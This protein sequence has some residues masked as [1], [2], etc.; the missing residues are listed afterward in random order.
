MLEVAADHLRVHRTGNA[1]RHHGDGFDSVA[2]LDS[3]DGPV[4]ESHD[5]ATTLAHG[6]PPA[7]LAEMQRR[8]P[9]FAAL[10]WDGRMLRAVRDPFGLVPLFYRI[11]GPAIWLSSEVAPLL[12]LGRPAS[13]LEAL[14]AR[15]AGTPLD[16]RTGWTGIHRVLPGS[17]VEVRPG[18][19]QVRTSRYWLAPTRL[20]ATFRGSLEEAVSEFRERLAAAVK[21]CLAPRSAILLSGGLDSA[22]VA[23]T[24]RAVG[25]AI[26]RLV[27]VHFPSLPATHEQHYAASVAGAVGA[28]LHT[29]TGDLTPWDI[30]AELD[31]HGIPYS[32]LP[33]GMD[34]PPLAYLAAAGLTVALDGHDGDGILGPP[35][36]AWGELILG[37]EL[38]RLAVLCRRGGLARTLRGAAADFVPH[39]LRPTRRRTSLA[40]RTARYFT[41]PLRSRSI[42]AH[43][44]WAWPS[45]RWRSMQLLP[46]LPRATVSFEQK[47]IEAARYGIDLRH[48]FADR[49]LAE[50]LISLPC[51]IK[52]DPGRAKPLLVDALGDALPSALRQRSKSDYLAAVRARVDAGRHLGGIRAS[53]I[54]LPHVDYRRLL[55]DGDADPERIPIHLLVGL[56][57]AHRFAERTA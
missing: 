43:D 46:L 44:P 51:A 55:D 32:W 39:F 52:S 5:G 11:C 56:A 21:R 42:A 23:V 54:R 15:A 49:E 28:A 41:E 17:T 47:E 6:C 10:D 20:L 35:S 9:R 50:F 38:R 19:M 37:C 2:F 4:V 33:F 18:E 53:R 24:A 1:V 36:V 16:E 34:E 14:S 22:A 48:P 27:H 29:V 7:P 45:R 25:E 57:R 31:L 13:D 3:V 8:A 26:P 12:A 30:D 40:Q